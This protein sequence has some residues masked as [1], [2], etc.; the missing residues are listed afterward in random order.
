MSRLLML[1]HRLPFPPN[2]GD[3]IRTFNVLAHLARSH[4]VTVGCLVDDPD[5]LRHL[6]A[7]DDYATAVGHARIDGTTRRAA[8]LTALLSSRS[9]TVTHFHHAALQAQV[10]AW[11]DERPFDAVLCCS[12]AMA[13][14]VF[15]SRHRD[16]SLAQA[17][18]V[19]DLIDVDSCK[20]IQYAEVAGPWISWLYRYEARTLGAYEQRIV[21]E[22]DRVFL[23]SPAEA[24]LL[25]SPA[26]AGRVGSFSNGV[27]LAYFAPRAPAGEA[28]TLV[29]TGVM[30][31]R[32]N[33]DAVE[34]FAREVL[35]RLR[36]ARPDVRF[37]IVGSR[38]TAQVRKLAS[39]EGV[40]VTGFVEDVRDWLARAAVCVAPL[41]I[42]RGVQNK[43]LEAMAMGLPVVATPQ[44]HEG[45]DAVAGRDL[46]VA[47]DAAAFAEAVLGLLR[48]RP[49]AAALGAAARRC[50][51]R[52]YRWDANLAVLD[53]VFG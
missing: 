52:H 14:Y 15:R 39:L 28:S 9:V 7:L 49:R 21:A 6:P 30:D 3:K 51:E 1:V 45:I 27:D 4:D 29:F 13:E 18:K 2:K 19:M 43:V 37:A 50:V 41:R 26:S 23:V 10:D 12:A 35:P 32:P 44:A 53:E 47:S 16:T 42:A 36:E 5:D 8:S 17:I 20:W 25:G 40:T 31:Y 38:P 11:I 24:R 33:I 34:W 46:L 22:F 48:D